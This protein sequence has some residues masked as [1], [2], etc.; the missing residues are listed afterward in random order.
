MPTSLRITSTLVITPL[1]GIRHEDIAKAYREGMSDGL[2][3]RDKPVP[4]TS[5]FTSLKRAKASG[6]F[7]GQHP[8]DTHDFVGF[9]L[10]CVHG[11][12]LTAHG[13]R[14]LNVVTL[15]SLDNKQARRGYHAG[16]HFFFEE[17]TPDE[18]GFTDTYVVE[19][20]SEWARDAA[21]WHEPDDVGQYAL[22]CLMGELSGHVFPVTQQERARWEREERK[23][24]AELAR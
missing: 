5:L 18:R 9:H 4:L 24:L 20:Y 17:I 21:E 22:A 8:N 10:G 6:V 7:D 11:A 19:R 15:V 23:V 2:R 3:H 12:I 14:R 16:R 13:T 1:I